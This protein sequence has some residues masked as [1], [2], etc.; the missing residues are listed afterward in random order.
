MEGPAACDGRK[1]R[2]PSCDGKFG[3]SAPP[4]VIDGA[5]VA[6]GL[7]GRVYVFEAATGKLLATH[8]TAVA[9]Q[10]V[11]KLAGRWRLDRRG[12]PVRRRR[13]A[14]RELGLRLSFGQQA[15]NA[16]VAYRPTSKKPSSSGRDCADR[17]TRAGPD[18]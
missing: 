8:D 4:L 13:P 18:Y 5:V 7:D 3:L 17:G 12:W 11:N 9:Y 10:G 15:G 14:V 16:L 2:V 1:A 6:G